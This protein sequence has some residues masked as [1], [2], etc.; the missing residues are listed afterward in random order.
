M[1]EFA[2]CIP[3][4]FFI[5]IAI[6]FFGRYFMLAQVMLHAAQEGAKLASRTPNL[7]NPDTRELVRGFTTSGAGSNPNSL[8][9]TA[10]GSARLLS[11]GA[12]GDLPAGA[13]V[14]V[15]PFDS[16]ADSANL[17]AGVVAVRIDYPFQMWG[18]PF[19]GPAP[20]VAI[21]FSADGSGN[22]FRFLNFVIS[23]QA[24]AAQ[25]IYQVTN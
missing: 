4:L 18:N 14:E 11:N 19:T 1:V 9:Y 25:E 22:S 10:L 15:L 17:P 24:V 7:N 6:L 5:M 20:S 8:I 3:F 21:K 2:L 16:A 13:K 12:T 23:Q